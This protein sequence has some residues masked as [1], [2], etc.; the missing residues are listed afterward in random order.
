MSSYES[1]IQKNEHE[2]TLSF[3]LDDGS[4]SV[5]PKNLW[6]ISMKD[7][8]SMLLDFYRQ[9]ISYYEM[10]TIKRILSVELSLDKLFNS[11]SYLKPHKDLVKNIDTAKYFLTCFV[12]ERL[13]PFDAYLT[14]LNDAF[15]KCFN[16]VKRNI[17]NLKKDKLRELVRTVKD[18]DI[19]R[20]TFLNKLVGKSYRKNEYKNY[21]ES[22][23]LFSLN[24]L[25]SLRSFVP[26]EE[27]YYYGEELLFNRMIGNS[28]L[29]EVYVFRK[30]SDAG[31]PCMFHLQMEYGNHGVREV[32]LLYW[33]DNGPG[34]VEVKTG[35]IN[36]DELRLFKETL[37]Q[38]SIDKFAVICPEDEV[39]RIDSKIAKPLT[40]KD[41]NDLTNLASLVDFKDL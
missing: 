21:Y 7:V 17:N 34:V 14:E 1:L 23:C 24:F 19:F 27:F 36:V 38:R 12:D 29:F 31:I 25:T 18:K 32:D 8:A 30:L 39:Q 22:I 4:V 10:R 6:Y 2:I 13:L 9:F 11:N 33:G 41:L 15:L 20:K 5:T 3:N 37:R 40:F 35:K 16:N 28:M 26:P